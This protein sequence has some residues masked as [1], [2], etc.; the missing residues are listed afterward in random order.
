MFSPTKNTN[1]TNRQW[2]G[3]KPFGSDWQKAS[4]TVKSRRTGNFAK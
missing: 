2:A 3:Q 1:L 4:L